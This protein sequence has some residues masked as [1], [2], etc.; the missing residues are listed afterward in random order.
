[1]R[2]LFFIL[3][4]LIEGFSGTA[5]SNG[6]TQTV[7]G[8]VVDDQSGNI[9]RNVT[10]QVVGITPAITAISDSTGV[11]KLLNVPIGRQSIRVSLVGFEDALMQNIELTSSKEVVLEIKMREKVKVLKE[12]LVVSGRSKNRAI[13][14]TAVVSARQLSM[15]EA[16]RYSGTRNDP[17]RMAQNFAGVSGPNDARND[18][19]IRG[20]SPS[21]VLWR[22]DGIDIP[23]PNHF[24]T[25]GS[26]GGPVT[27]LNTNTLKNSDFIT[28]AFPSQYGNAI[29]GV[30][31][32]RMRNGNNEKN[33]YLGQMGFNG[34]EFGAEGPLSKKHTSSF[35]VNYRYSMVATIQALGLNVG[36]G[37]ATPY[38]QDASFKLHLVTKKAGSFDIF[39][40]GGE[41]HITFLPDSSQNLYA[42]NDGNPR[43]STT[44]SLTGVLGVTHTYFFNR[45]TSGKFTVALS[46]FQSKYNEHIN[47]PG[48]P[49]KTS[50]DVLNKQTKLS[51]GY[52]FNNKINAANQL[53]F[54]IVADI[55]FLNLNQKY[56]PDGDTVLRTLTNAQNTTTL[57]K[58]FVNLNHRFT[59]TL[60]SNFGIYSQ[61]LSLNGST[62]IEPRWNIRYQFRPNQ[63]FS[64]GT[65]LHSQM[66]P[67]QVYFY[68]YTNTAGQVQLTNKNL[69]FV[70]S[71]H[72]VAG[73]DI[74]LPNH[75]RVKTE[76]YGQYIFNA[77]VETL[78]SS[79]S[80]LNAGAGFTFPDKSWLQNK[81][82]GKNYGWELTIEKFLHEGFYY[83]FTGSLFESKYAGSDGIW[84]NTAFNSH[85]VA[86]LLGGKEFKINKA[87]AFGIDTRF[88]VA[89]GQR[90]TP[91]DIT[92]S[93]ASNSVVYEDYA[94]Y[95]LHNNDYLRLDL[96][97]SVTRNGKKATQKWF[98]DFQNLT[99][100]K[101]IYLRTLNVKTGAISEINQI[102]FFPNINYQ[103]TF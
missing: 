95:S 102:G 90:Y 41:A 99:G 15:D 53:T 63:A 84:R 10:V 16:V 57:V 25:V 1:M 37:S 60:S 74:N 24:S 101:N 21:G 98:I 97:F 49:E 46:G 34:F 45:N 39:G 52:T 14:E 69:D 18:I 13:N 48:K 40:L 100:R 55:N 61:V 59:N 9:L 75:L 81:G 33:E 3:C 6:F 68:Q 30:F 65:G 31:D 93:K 92:A 79:F 19:V 28:S 8:T 50:Y 7:K 43:T 89:G 86:N 96:K 85:Y 12:V 67:L 5:Q 22:M 72:A 20:N 17:S 103:I 44:N 66:Q 38:Y 4:L 26:T 35:L 71:V 36:T 42:T 91:F 2:K 83:L 80:M 70:K 73:Y 88:V 56:I 32:L 23:N 29:A 76:I 47:N 27:I 64:I 87:T 82:K 54:G 11:F 77:A 78:P 58:G 62:S 51:V 94:A